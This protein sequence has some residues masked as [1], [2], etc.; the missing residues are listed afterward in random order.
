MRIKGTV[1][2]FH[3]FDEIPVLDLSHAICP[4]KKNS[5][6]KYEKGKLCHEKG[7]GHMFVCFGCSH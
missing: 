7:A 6:K 2:I 5:N 3:M 1:D 4:K